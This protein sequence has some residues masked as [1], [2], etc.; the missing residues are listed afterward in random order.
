[1]INNNSEL[2]PEN[3]QSAR[4][5]VDWIVASVHNKIFPTIVV[6]IFMTFMCT[7]WLLAPAGLL[8]KLALIVC[9]IP[10]FVLFALYM[11]GICE[12]APSLYEFYKRFKREFSPKKNND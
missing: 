3:I 6:L 5:I 12:S 10:A 4:G 9:S 7:M 1:M 11:Y 8:I 2:K